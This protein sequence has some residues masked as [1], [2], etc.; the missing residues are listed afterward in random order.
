MSSL[1]STSHARWITVGAVVVAVLCG[2]GMALQSRLNGGLGIELGSATAAA[3]WSFGSGCVILLVVLAAL[4]S[5]RAGVVSLVGA[6]RSGTVPWWGLTGGVVGAFFVL[7]QG[8][9][10]GL[11]GVALFTVSYVAGQSIGSV[12]IDR[13]GV[14]GMHPRH[15]TWPRILGAVL[16]LAAVMLASWGRIGESGAPV[17]AY[18]LPFI[19][20][21]FVG[22]QQAVNGLVRHAAGSGLVATGVN[23]AVGAVLL[24]IAALVTVIVSG[25]PAGALRSPVLLLGGIVGI[26]FILGMAVVVRRLGVLVLGLGTIAGQLAAAVALDAAFP[27][28]GHPLQLT[29]ILASAVALVAVTIAAVPRLFRR[30]AS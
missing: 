22:W 11:I 8:L 1:S 17:W 7:S 6:L 25:P 29:T 21:A 19:A 3:L 5:G 30:R 10:A 15:I 26:G 12:V 24:G 2:A 4:P 27:A 18:V 14:A 16:A 28:A 13:L 20:G 23:F 9:A